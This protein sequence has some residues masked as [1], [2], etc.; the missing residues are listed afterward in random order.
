LP[1]FK[2][3]TLP[4]INWMTK[5]FSIKVPVIAKPAPCV[6]PTQCPPAPTPCQQATPCQEV[7]QGT[8]QQPEKIHHGNN[9]IVIEEEDIKTKPSTVY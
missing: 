1:T 8:N 2:L 9:I 7:E 5:W 3:P 4:K 6:A